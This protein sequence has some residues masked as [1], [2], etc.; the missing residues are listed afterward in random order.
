MIDYLK[1][2]AKNEI[3]VTVFGPGYGESIAVHLGGGEW[4]LIDSCIDPY[5]GE[6]ASGSYLDSI[7]VKPD[8]VRSIVAS[9]WHDDHVRGISRLATKYPTADFVISAVF[10]DKEALAFL[11]AYNGESSSGL[12]RGAKELF[13]VIN[14]RDNVYPAL[15]KSII[16][17]DKF[18]DVSIKVTAFSPVPAAFAQSIAHLAHY[19]PKNGNSINNAP[20]IHPNLE[21]I[22]VHIDLGD[23]AILLGSD[24]EN[25]NKLGWTAIID[26]NWSGKRVPATAYKV[27]HHGSYTGDTPNI[28]SKLLSPEPIA[29]LTSYKLA[30]KYLP[31][32]AD[33]ERVKENTQHAYIAS[34]ASRKPQMDKGQLKRLKDIATNITLL[35]TGFGAIRLRKKFNEKSWSIELFGAAQRL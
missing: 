3:E 1:S 2:P 27:A 10:N 32:D 14:T 13:S 18:N 22:V 29:C 6:S 28:W 24:L 31:T 23:D 33:K 30:G 11:S 20:E 12:A 5:T 21:S 19:L 4:I 26:D 34:G 15:H 16:L 25:H 8:K 17:D 35:D 7:G 9:H